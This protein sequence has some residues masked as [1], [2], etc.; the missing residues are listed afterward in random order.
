MQIQFM[1]LQGKTA[2]E[3]QILLYRPGR[4]VIKNQDDEFNR[5]IVVLKG[6]FDNESATS[7]ENHRQLNASS[8]NLSSTLGK[9]R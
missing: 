2:F 6:N 9:R 8:F 7:E 1:N 4:V 5:G 3:H